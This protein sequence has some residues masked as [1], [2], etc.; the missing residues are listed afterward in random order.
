MSSS[1]EQARTGQVAAAI[2]NDVVR[3]VRAQTGRG[4]TFAKTTISGDLVVCVLADTLTVGERTLV[5]NGNAEEVLATRKLF[6]N[7]MRLNLTGAVETHT[8]RRVIAFMSDNHIEPDTAVEA[9]ILEPRAGAE[10]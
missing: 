1:P 3:I 6:Q 2:S 8:G 9:F 10:S 7:A 4:P 5:D